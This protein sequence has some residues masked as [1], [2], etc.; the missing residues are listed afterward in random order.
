MVTVL[1]VEQAH[2][3][4][5]VIPISMNLT[6]PLARSAAS[7]VLATTI[8]GASLG[9]QL[10]K[11]VRA[12]VGSVAPVA[13]IQFPFRSGRATTGDS[14]PSIRTLR[15]QSDPYGAW[16]LTTTSDG[17]V[18]RRSLAIGAAVGAVTGGAAGFILYR[19]SKFTKNE[20]WP[21]FAGSAVLGGGILG[22]GVGMAV[23][24]FLIPD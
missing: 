16:F 17:R 20:A 12:G 18:S 1:L 23:V 10:I 11:D 2:R 19:R 14:T 21:L 5:I 8:F 3:L 4:N 9:A 22:A 24:A 6:R 15:T 13:R 7:L